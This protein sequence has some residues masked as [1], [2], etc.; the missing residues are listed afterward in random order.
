MGGISQPELKN[1]EFRI[2]GL[3]F[4]FPKG[5]RIRKVRSDEEDCD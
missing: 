1:G 5:D 4:W 2:F 3:P